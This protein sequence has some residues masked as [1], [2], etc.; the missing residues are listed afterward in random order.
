VEQSQRQAFGGQGQSGVNEE[1]EV[2]GV[3]QLPQAAVACRAG[4]VD[5]GGVLSHQ[6]DTGVTIGQIDRRTGVGVVDVVGIDVGVVE[7]TVGGIGGGK[8]ARGGGDAVAG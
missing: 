8:V 6:K 4:K 3:G 1:A 7:E 5:V 2:L